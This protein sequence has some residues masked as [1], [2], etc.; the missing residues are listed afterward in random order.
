MPMREAARVACV[1]QAFVRS[2]RCHPNFTFTK[3]TLCLNENAHGK[4]EM[5]FT[6]IVDCILKKHSGVGVKTLHLPVFPDRNNKDCCHLYHLD[7]WLQIAVTPGIQE[8]ILKAYSVN[9]KYNFPY[10]VLSDGTVDSLRYFFLAYCDFH[11]T[12]RLGLKS[13][14][15]LDMHSVC[16]T[17]GELACLLSNSFAL[18]QLKLSSCSEIM[19]LKIPCLKRL[20]CLEVFSCTRL[21]VI[22]GEAPNLSSFCV[23]GELQVSLGETLRIEKLS[24]SCCPNGTFYARTELPSRMPNL[25]TLMIHSNR[26]LV[27]TPMMPSKFLH[28]KLLLIGLGCD[29]DY[30]SLV[31]FLDASPSLEDFTLMVFRFKEPKSIFVDRSDLRKM[32]EHRY[33]KLKNV[34]VINFTSERTL[35]ELACQILESATS[36]ECLTV[37]ATLELRCRCSVNKSVHCRGLTDRRTLEEAR[38]ALVAAETYIKPK[39]PHTVE[40]KAVEPCRR[41]NAVDP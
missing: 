41:C 8:L 2:W 35:V 7:I 9:T 23:S 6:S 27:N 32:P 4:D 39:I 14:T 17:D 18:E 12:T 34:E 3:E 30:F 10:S 5:D 37:D 19:C 22:E 33:D 11:P 15:R 21:Q 20:I 1:S 13:L 26:E 24:W 36:L 40:F 29:I 25:R 16:I 31:S 38:R 28:L